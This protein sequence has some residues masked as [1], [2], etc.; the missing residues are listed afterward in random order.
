MSPPTRE[1][2]D[3]PDSLYAYLKNHYSILPT[4][5]IDKRILESIEYHL[6]RIIILDGEFH[7]PDRNITG[8]KTNETVKCEINSMKNEYNLCV[9]IP[10]HENLDAP[11]MD[12]STPSEGT[13]SPHIAQCNPSDSANKACFCKG[14]PEIL[15]CNG[16][17]I[18]YNDNRCHE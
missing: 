7:Y 5:K 12:G 9:E 1:P 17:S 6:F 16:V 4:D 8:F 10:T 15:S 3:A 13:S 2:T 14:P 18:Q 11:L